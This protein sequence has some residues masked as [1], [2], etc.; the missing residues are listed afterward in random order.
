[1]RK[2]GHVRLLVVLVFLVLFGLGMSTPGVA[3]ASAY[4]G[5]GPYAVAKST[6]SDQ[7][8]LFTPEG[9]TGRK[10]PAI[11]FA[12][13][14][15]GP[16][17]RYSSTLE[18]LASW[19]FVVLANQKQEDCGEG[20]IRH[21]LESAV[22]FF[23]PGGKFSQAADSSAM[24]GHLRD[25][26]AYL[27]ERK[28]VDANALALV[29]HSMGGGVVIDVA[30]GLAGSEPGLLKAVVAIAPWNG[31]KPIPSSVVGQIQA[32]ILIFCSMS[33]A[34]CPC[35]G[36]ATITDTQG[37]IT[38]PASVGIPILFGPGADVNWNGGALAIYD[39]ATNAT[40]MEVKNVNHFV[41][42]G[43]DGKQMDDLAV[44]ARVRY[45]LNFN[46]LHRSYVRIP[47]LGY[48]VDFL[49][50]AL[51]LG[52]STATDIVNRAKKD[53]RIDKVLTK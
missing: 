48:S 3:R 18:T 31:A 32:P 46:K 47:T 9:H 23:V 45:G 43:T 27:R 25:N 11:V 41:I 2:V 39:N 38:Q 4:E 22:D 52:D 17:L 29:G 26:L 8:L 12:H 40:L 44:W 49:Y 20:N 6:V 21:P 33:D 14:L 34:L 50:D 10:W 51:Q 28:D 7:G 16:A 53:A 15:C 5:K 30:A 24:A 42:A 1:M 35:S 19:G 37:P 36:P 13:G